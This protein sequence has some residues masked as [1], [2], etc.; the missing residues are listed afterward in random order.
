LEAKAVELAVIVDIGSTFTKAVLVDIS[1]GCLVAR[2]QTPTT[3]ND[4]VQKGLLKAENDLLAKAQVTPQQVGLRLAASSAAGGLRMVTIGLVPELT[5]EAARLAALGAGARV[6]AVFSYK[7]NAADLCKIDALHPDVLLMAGGADGG[8]YETVVHNANALANLAT[9]PP[10][11]Y[12]GNIN[13]ADE[14]ST[15]LRQDGFDVRVT[16]NVMPRLGRLQVDETRQA[17]RKVFLESIVENKGLDVVRRWADNNVVPTPAAVQSGVAL[18][19]EMLQVDKLLAFDI[20]GATTDVY[21][22][23]GSTPRTG[24]HLQGLPMPHRMRTVEGDLGLRV[25]LPSLLEAMPPCDFG[26]LFGIN[27]EQVRPLLS[28]LEED[29]STPLPEHIDVALARACVS[30]AAVRHAGTIELLPTPMG[31]TGI[32]RG[33]DLSTAEVVI[34]TGGIL[35]RSPHIQDILASCA[36]SPRNPLSLLPTTVRALQDKDYILYAA[37][38]LADDHRDAAVELLR[39]SLRANLET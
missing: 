10:V 38:L 9:R 25:S 11:V 24:A 33:K 3:V 7:L 15:V 18:S 26:E 28:Q 23:G 39:E 29:Y 16:A 5:A 21:S 6:M 22:I 17:I 2:A 30:I 34:G 20:G 37:G 4:G 27:V 13:A 32:Q 19:A 12:A 35:S 1:A 14:V 36:A 31:Y 8:D